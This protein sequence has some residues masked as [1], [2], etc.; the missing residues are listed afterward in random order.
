MR[1]AARRQKAVERRRARAR[2]SYAANPEPERERLRQFHAAHPEK[3]RQYQRRFKERHP[4]RAAEQARRGS[5]AWRDRNAETAREAQR[6]QAAQRR[7][8]DPDVFRRWYTANLE[9]EREKGREKS[10]LRSRLKKL[11]LPPPRRHR[12][13]AEQKRANLAAADAFFTR[14]RNAPERARTARE[15]TVPQGTN[16]ALAAHRR[17]RQIASGVAPLP[18]QD[19]TLARLPGLVN[20]HERLHGNAIREEIRMDSIA[21]QLRGRP[22]LDIARETT[23]RAWEEVIRREAAALPPERLD[24]LRKLLAPASDNPL[25]PTPVEHLH[26]LLDTRI[27]YDRER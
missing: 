16:Y 19:R 11:E 6:Q 17:R 10:R 4:E 24:Q 8:K 9:R 23:N 27:E 18:V 20:E 7:E 3:A 21:R 13:Y 1:R 14:K 5:Q 15:L 25:H 12:V 26:E 2:E 22:A